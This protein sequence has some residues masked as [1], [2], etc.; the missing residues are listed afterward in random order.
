MDNKE[1][2]KAI[3][4]LTDA[5]NSLNG[6]LQSTPEEQGYIP[7]KANQAH[8]PEPEITH[9]DFADLARSKM[10]EGVLR[11]EIVA[12]IKSMGYDNG[13][14]N[15]PRSELPPVYEALKALRG[16]KQNG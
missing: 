4:A 8:I 10:S 13:A 12:L 9:G 11:S 3:N 7:P 16:G 2:I 14:K 5:V 6:F 1:L 15:I